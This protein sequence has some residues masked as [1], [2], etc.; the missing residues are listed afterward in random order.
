MTSANQAQLEAKLVLDKKPTFLEL[1]FDV[2]G[3][4]I[5]PCDVSMELF[6]LPIDSQ[7]D[8]LVKFGSNTESN[9]DEIIIL[10]EGDYQINVAQYIY[11]LII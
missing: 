4:V 11:E 7:F 9:S 5:L 10:P 3:K 2:Q 6:D 8:L 1:S